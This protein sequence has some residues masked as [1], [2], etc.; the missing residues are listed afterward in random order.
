MTMCVTKVMEKM[1]DFNNEELVRMLLIYMNK[2]G[3]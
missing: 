3:I 2:R 1:C